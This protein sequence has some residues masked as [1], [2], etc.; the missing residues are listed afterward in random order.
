MRPSITRMPP[1]ITR[2]FV[3]SVGAKSYLKQNKIWYSY[4]DVYYK[5]TKMKSMLKKEFNVQSG[6]RVVIL[7]KNTV[8][9]V[10]TF[11]AAL[12]SGALVVPL[13]ST[14][15]VLP[16]ILN[17]VEPKVIV[18]VDSSNTKS[19]YPL[20]QA[21]KEINRYCDTIELVTNP[22]NDNALVLYTSGTSGVPKGVVL[23]HKNIL[24]N[25][26]GIDTMFGKD[27]VSSSDKSVNFLPWNHCYGLTCELLYLT[28]KKASIVINSDIK[29]V[30]RDFSSEKPN[31]LFGVP[32]L[33]YKL[34]TQLKN[35]PQFLLPTIKNYILGN[36]LRC[37]TTGG[38][39][40]S[41][42]VIDFF[43]NKLDINLCQGY[44][45]T[46]YSPMVSVNPPCDNRIGSVGRL[47]DNTDIS[48]GKEGEIFIKGDSL[49]SHYYGQ[50]GQTGWYDTGDKGYV[51]DEYLYITG[52]TKEEYKLLNGKFVNPSYVEK[53]ILNS[54]FITQAFVYGLN[55]PYNVCLL[56]TTLSNSQ[57]LR[58]VK[59]M[60]QKLSNYEIPRKVFILQEDFTIENDLLTAKMSMKRQ[61]ILEKYSKCIESLYKE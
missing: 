26:N 28:S 14:N 15:K 17:Q 58:E 46:E 10:V 11:F 47:L 56:R 43:I 33:Y 5:A 37:A 6:D 30:L 29:N 12:S 8:S 45:L 27:F 48:F 60:C 7:G 16:Q 44:G 51:K 57:A 19:R 54:Q 36:Q 52:R 35:Y 13:S 53:Q 55:K 23:S 25:I 3:N 32:K 24:N 1:S 20:L 41:E 4:E 50:Q 40:I 21:E 18:S 34:Y 39:E 9:W 61:K 2:I 38:A 31:I 22:T 49:F 59:R 42:E